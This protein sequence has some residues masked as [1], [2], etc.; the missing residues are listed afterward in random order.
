[1]QLARLRRLV[2]PVILTGLMACD[3]VTWGGVELRLEAPPATDTAATATADTVS[4][5][6][7]TLP[8]LDLGPSLFIV[9]R[10]E[11]PTTGGSTARLMPVAL[12]GSD[13]LEPFPGPDEV[14]RIGERFI[15]E[16]MPPDR[17]FVLYAGGARVGSFFPDSVRSTARFGAPAP[18]SEE[19]APDG[20]GAAAPPADGPLCT[21]RPAV[22]GWVE[23]LPEAAGESRL[24]ALPEDA[25]VDPGHGRYVA[26]ASTREQRLAALNLA[27]A[28]YVIR[29][30]VWPPSVTEARQDMSVFRPPGEDDE[31]IAATFLYGDS[32]A[33]GPAP[34]NAYSLFFIG[35]PPE[36]GGRYQEDY[37]RY[38][39]VGPDGKSVPRWINHV[40]WDGDQREDVLL[41]VFGETG[42]SFA[43]L[44]RTDAGW[45][46]VFE[47]GCPT[48]QP[49]VASGSDSPPAGSSAAGT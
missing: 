14:E 11:A 25:G 4:E 1:V 45:E 44:S 47:E 9:D 31:L 13:G 35:R 21:P 49:A 34:P 33:V 12:L 23:L 15:R 8:P 46:E 16:R 37:V 40:D 32:L 36:G 7:R 24:I 39:E 41:E 27:S 6:E 20:P 22:A 28:L 10:R 38:R 3:N 2:I 18:G 19:G 26:R 5:A 48:P 29:D 43:A 42:R 17:R 30:I